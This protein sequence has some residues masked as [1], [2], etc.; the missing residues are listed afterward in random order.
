MTYKTPWAQRFPPLWM[1]PQV[2]INHPCPDPIQT[3][4]FS[5]AGEGRASWPT[6]INSIYLF[7]SPG[8]TQAESFRV[9]SVVNVPACSVIESCL[10]LC[11]PMD[12]SPPSSSVYE[13]SQGRI[14]EWVVIYFSRG[15]SWPRNW[16]C[17]SCIGRQIL[18]HWATS[19]ALSCKEQ[20]PPLDSV[21]KAG[22][23]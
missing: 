10:T 8:S 9:F 4:P 17:I 7:W 6:L 16:T 11:D 22:P 21:T 18:Y 15:S 12:C 13:I 20:M 14:L 23:S 3:Q 5:E 2:N 1:V 19:E